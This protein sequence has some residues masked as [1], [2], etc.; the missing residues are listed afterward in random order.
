ML[1][2]RDKS[3]L[4]I[5]DVQTRLA[6]AIHDGQRVVERCIWLAGVPTA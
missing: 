2:N 6:P 5:I 4:L 1:M 3:T